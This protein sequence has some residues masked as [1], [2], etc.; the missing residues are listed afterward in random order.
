MFRRILVP[1][2]GSELSNKAVT[3]AIAL[4]RE[5]RASIVALNVQAEYRPPVVAEV[6][7]G[8]IYSREEY[9]AGATKVAQ[10]LLAD[11]AD[12]AK[13][14]SVEVKSVAQLAPNPWEAIIRVARE[15]G[16][17]LIFMASHG[18]RGVVGLLLGSETQKVLT[19][20]KV[21]VL[22]YR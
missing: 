20:C 9:E 5:S 21:P 22:V 19:H 3:A 18:R 6:P 13:S 2:D 4:A 1:T 11:V 16:C 7:V 12:R 8:D 17:D 10:K 15:E 14:A